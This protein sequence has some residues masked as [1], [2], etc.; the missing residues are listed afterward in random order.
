M[1]GRKMICC[2][3]TVDI[4]ADDYDTRQT[5]CQPHDVDGTVEPETYQRS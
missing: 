4:P 5:Q 3:F 2:Q 1:V